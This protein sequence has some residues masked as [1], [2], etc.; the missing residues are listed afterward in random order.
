MTKKTK[1][2]IETTAT[3]AIT[4]GVAS[5]LYLLFQTSETHI[6]TAWPEVKTGILVCQAMAAT[7][8]GFFNTNGAHSVGQEVK[9]TFMGDRLDK[10]NYAYEGIYSSSAEATKANDNL[11]ADYNIYMGIDAEKFTPNFSV[12]E[13]MLKINL[14]A[15]Q[16]QMNAKIGKIFY[17]SSEEVANLTNYTDMEL[18][19]LYQN[20]GFSCE[21][22][23]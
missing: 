10:L 20:K 9:I 3:V 18:K 15:E 6:T 17:L 23:N 16:K 19:E 13:D 8:E 4:V 11:H 12:I 14:F 1:L 21:L 5:A 2:I 7:D 22:N